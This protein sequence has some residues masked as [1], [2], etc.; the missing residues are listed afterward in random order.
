MNSIRSAKN[1]FSL[2]YRIVDF[3]ERLRDGHELESDEFETALFE[4]AQYF[5]DKTA[6]DAIGLDDDESTCATVSLSPLRLTD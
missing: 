4:T 5:A 3:S 2:L 6:L 1:G